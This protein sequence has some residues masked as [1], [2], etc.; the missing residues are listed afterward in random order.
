MS[1]GQNTLTVPLSATDPD[2]DALTY[3]ATVLTPSASLYQL[4]QQLGL[5]M[6]NGSYYT[7]EWGYGEK[8]LVGA[9]G[10][11]Y[12]LFP[13]GQL[14]RWSG[15]I[16]TTMTAANLVATL[17]PSVYANPELLWNAQP[18]VAPAITLSI[19]GNQLTVQRP[20]GLTGVFQVQVGVTD[21]V[22]SVAQTFYVT[23]G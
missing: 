15:L 3:T 5:H 22:S 20:A 19:Q 16:T 4:N 17:D 23:L 7:N 2:G 21:G 11:W 6:Y 13:G 1:P 8:W 18:P 9:N 14:Y 10:A 12:G